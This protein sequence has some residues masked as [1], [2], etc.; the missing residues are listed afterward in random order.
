MPYQI[1][2]SSGWFSFRRT[3]P[4]YTNNQTRASVSPNFIIKC[5]SNL[6]FVSTQSTVL[7]KG[8]K[9]ESNGNLSSVKSWHFIFPPWETL[10]QKT[11]ISF[12]KVSVKWIHDFL[13]KSILVKKAISKMAEPP[14]NGSGWLFFNWCLF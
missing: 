1:W 7:P 12:L 13:L 5:I 3:S 11:A 4:T 9:F 2:T 14:G 8:W 10:E 6:V